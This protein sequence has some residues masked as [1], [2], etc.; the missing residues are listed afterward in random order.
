MIQRSSDFLLENLL[1]Q[2][3]KRQANQWNLIASENI[4]YPTA[5]VLC[6]SILTNK[7]AE[8][9]PIKRFYQG[10]G[11]INEIETLA[12][13]RAQRLFQAEYA[14]VQPHCGSSANLIAYLGLLSKG[15]TIL[16]MDFSCG[17][18]LSHGHP[19]NIS[20]QLF[21]FI[22]YGVDPLTHLIDYNQ[23]EHLLKIHK[24]K[25]LLSGASSYSQLIDYKRMYELARK[26]NALHMVDMAHIAGLVAGGIIENPTPYADIVTSTTHK[27]LRGP[28]GAFILA[29]EEFAKKI[30]LA[31]MPGVQGGPFMNVIAAKAWLFE[32]ALTNDFIDYQKQ[33]IT[34][35]NLMVDILKKRD[36]PI[37]SDGS[38]NHLFV[39]D[40][41]RLNK[42]GHAAAEL[43]EK[44]N[45]IVNKNAIPYDKNSPFITSGIRIGTPW[46]T[47]QKKTSQE[48]TIKTNEIATLL[49]Q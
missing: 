8:G 9:T 48:I 47:A 49:L 42:T 1:T 4:C 39:I 2:E 18:H 40:V 44:H 21:N 38:A 36:I 19:K 31:T 27:T 3:A 43:L 29:K 41:S 10:C 46:I 12:I 23:I 34:N 16:S 33:I 7:Y 14:N 30:D 20:S 37:I 17:G 22:H 13:Q 15:D 5:Q 45:I 35:C 32:Y 25:L 6:G 26:Y 24:P 28:R 11:N